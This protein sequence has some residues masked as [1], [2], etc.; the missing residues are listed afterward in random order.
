M[1]ILVPVIV[2][3]IIGYFTNWLAIKMLFRPHHEKRIMNIKI[4]F[5]PGL[6]PKERERIAKS[7]GETVGNYLL[8]PETIVEAL[9]NKRTDREIKL[10]L[11]DKLN[12]LKENQQ[13]MKG[14]LDNLLGENYDRFIKKAKE[15]LKNIIISHI[16]SEQFKTLISKAIE[17]KVNSF[18]TEEIYGLVDEKLRGSLIELSKS[19]ELKNGIIRH[20]DSKLNEFA[21]DERMLS[22]LIPE[23]LLAAIN[24]Y[25]DENGNEIGY[26]IR[27]SFKD[28][29]IQRKIKDSIS[30]LISQNMSKLIIAFISPELISDKVFHMI[31]K[32]I[33][34]EDAN[35]NIVMLV[36]AS[37]DKLLESKASEVVPRLME[38]IGH[39]SLA[40][41]SDVLI[42]YIS[43]EKNYDI[44]LQLIQD[45]LKASELNNK[46]NIINY[47]NTNIDII[48]NSTKLEE[49]IFNFTQIIVE[50]FLNKPISSMA[51]KINKDMITNIYNIARTI[52][53]E[54]AIHELPH[55]I[56]L[57][58]ISK[59]VEDK[60]NSFDVDFTEELILDIANKELKAITW[61]G[62]LLGGVL[63]ILTP[64]IQMLY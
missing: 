48:L 56:E 36:K 21:Q 5:T 9:A 1:K 25:I 61:L 14:I 30:E 57:F 23:E 17:D 3:A 62:A 28:P 24:Q 20:L 10:W 44:M 16:R 15:N 19:S 39:D 55:I 26:S 58:N 33:D 2:G 52:F 31:E 22:Q 34:S 12:K 47:L 32:Y 41:I 43:D 63:G 11:E 64:L 29:E 7:I 46:E 13:S 8:S 50:Q 38:T 59:I 18:D 45:K 53:E 51:E 54:F 35:K 6:I 37:I 40:R 60:V 4:P 49:S 42:N 27:T